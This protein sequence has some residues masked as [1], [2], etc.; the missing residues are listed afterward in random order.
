[1][2]LARKDERFKLDPDDHATLEEICEHAGMKHGDWLESIIV[3]ILRQKARE[4]L[5]LAE[6]LKRRGITGQTRE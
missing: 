3:P 6:R 2:S 5:E 4:T 1:M